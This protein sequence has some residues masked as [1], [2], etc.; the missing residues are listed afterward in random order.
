M[1]KINKINLF[2]SF[3][4]FFSCNN[5]N[6][7]YLKKT[8]TLDTVV[9]FNDSIYKNADSAIKRGD[10][11]AYKKAYRYFSVNHY[12]KEFL[13]YSITMAHTYDWNQAYFDTYIILTNVN[14]DKKISNKNLAEYYLLKSYEKNNRYAKEIVKEIF[15]DKGLKVPNSNSVLE[16]EK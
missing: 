5:K 9:P 10:T 2:L 7:N 3:L 11:L 13:Y 4:L 12:E 15:L 8:E 1:K 16:N 6:D 14:D